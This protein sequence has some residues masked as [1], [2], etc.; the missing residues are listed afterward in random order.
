MKKSILSFTI[1]SIMALSINAEVNSMKYKCAYTDTNYGNGKFTLTLNSN[2]SVTTQNIDFLLLEWNLSENNIIYIQPNNMDGSFSINDGIFY[3]LLE[4]HKSEIGICKAESN[5]KLGNKAKHH[6]DD[7]TSTLDKYKN[8]IS[9]YFSSTSENDNNNI[10]YIMNPNPKYSKKHQKLSMYEC[11]RLST[12]TVDKLQLIK[13][14]DEDMY[15]SS[16][17]IYKEFL[18]TTNKEFCMDRIVPGEQ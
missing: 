16:L 3:R 11:Q 10:Y 8:S 7:F 2:K 17:R 6:S 5:D 13:L 9:D 4:E 18:I 15:S 14:R 1:L 12:K